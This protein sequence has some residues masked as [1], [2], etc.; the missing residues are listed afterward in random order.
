MDRLSKT[1]WR[2]KPVTAAVFLLILF[3][4]IPSAAHAAVGTFKITVVQELSRSGGIFTYIFK[5][6]ETE[7]PMP[8][9][10]AAEGYVFSIAGTNIAEIEIPNPGRRGVYRYLL[11]QINGAEEPGRISD[12]RVYT[13]EAHT[14]GEDFRIIV[15]NE[16]KTKADEIIFSNMN[17]F[18]PTDPDLMPDTPVRKTVFGSPAGDGV[19]AFALVSRDPSAPMPPGSVNGTKIIHITGSGGVTFGVWSYDGPGTHYYTV[20]ELNDGID[21]YTYD[22][23]VYTITDMVKE[24]NGA[25]TLTRVVTNGSNKPVSSF[26]FNNYYNAGEKPANPP[27]ITIPPVTKAPPDTENPY[28]TGGPAATESSYDAY[29]PANTESSYDAYSPDD[30]EGPPDTME[31]RPVSYDAPGSPDPSDADGGI[32]IINASA[33]SDPADPGFNL[34]NPDIPADSTGADSGAGP[35][36]G[37]GANIGFLYGLFATGGAIAAGALF[38]LIAGERLGKC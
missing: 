28:D 6:L 11:F 18:V 23:A 30:T 38:Y 20:Y 25:L 37:D 36:T 17:V 35:K 16:D 10:S 33:E 1:N 9:G 32:D 7:N 27:A 14:D 8:E 4:F 34:H 21:G 19:F 12:T 13:I 22:D 5:P 26:I 24:K 29:N 31:A 2:K 15:M 3:A